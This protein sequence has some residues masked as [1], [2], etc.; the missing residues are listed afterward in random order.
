MT[1]LWVA[2]RWAMGAAGY[3]AQCLR[4]AGKTIETCYSMGLYYSCR[5]CQL[6]NL[7][8]AVTLRPG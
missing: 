2:Q 8:K 5:V 1:L 4:E 3:A 6:Q 7:H